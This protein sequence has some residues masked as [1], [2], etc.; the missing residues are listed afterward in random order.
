MPYSSGLAQDV[1]VNSFHFDGLNGLEQFEKIFEMV[2]DFYNDGTGMISPVGYY[3]SAYIQRSPTVANVKVYNWDN[4]KPRPPLFE[5]NMALPA[6]AS[7]TSLPF[8]VAL[9]SS[10]AGQPQAGVSRARQRGR[11]Y[12][13]PFVTGAATTTANQPSRPSG[14]LITDAGAAME[15][16]TEQSQTSGWPTF[17]VYSRVNQTLYPVTHGWVDNEWDTQRRRQ[18]KA[19]S[20]LQWPV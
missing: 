4:E 12:L 6:A 15:R 14:S 8:E 20:R 2:S 10:Y 5:S 9:C 18:T 1:V 3:L 16:L 17:C 13:G 19:T 11:I 7:A